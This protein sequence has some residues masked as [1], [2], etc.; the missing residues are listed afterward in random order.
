M[1]AMGQKMQQTTQQTAH[2]MNEED[3]SGEEPSESRE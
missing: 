2:G 3:S 1:A